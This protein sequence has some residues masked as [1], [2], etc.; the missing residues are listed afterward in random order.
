MAMS[1]APA[2]ATDARDLLLLLLP[3]LAVPLADPDFS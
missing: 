1:H 2:H 3:P